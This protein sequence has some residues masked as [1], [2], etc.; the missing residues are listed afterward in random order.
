MLPLS[1]LRIHGRL[2]GFGFFMYFCSSAGQTFFIALFGGELRADFGLSHGTFGTIYAVA[3]LASAATLI[4]IGRLIDRVRL[5]LFAAGVLAG[6]AG[7]SLLTSAIWSAAALAVALF[8]LRLFGQG[9]SGHTAATAMGRYF[10]AE[11]GRA[12]S[13]AVMG[14]PAGKF[15][16]PSL[17]VAGLAVTDW[18]SLWLV[19]AIVLAAAIP[20]VFVLLD[21]HGARDTALRL[22]RETGKSG[23]TGDRALGA[24]LRDAGLWLR[25][26]ALL[27]TPAIFTG[28]IFHQVHLAAA[29]GWPLSLIAGSFSV[30]AVASIAGTLG[31]GPLVDRVGA[32]RLVSVFLAPLLL[33]CLALGLGNDPLAAPLFLGLMGLATGISFVIGGALWPELYG[34]TH[35]GAIRAFTQAVMVFATGFAPAAVGL[36]IDGGVS[37]E[38]IALACAAYCLVAAA[39][40][41]TLRERP[42]AAR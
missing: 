9:L 23:G 20:L 14:L 37:V 24:V 41:A 32:R 29:K 3:T 6:L 4:W 30:F 28:L 21:G 34:T 27:A 39:L 1:F 19:T 17:V 26:P 22:R 40:A 31:A 18:R 15:V 36:A 10:E 5:P 25:L 12:L 13:I 33:S 16:L 7:V 2:I 11:R 8:G 35:L 38:R 42:R